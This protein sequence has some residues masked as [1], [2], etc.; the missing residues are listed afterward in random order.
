[1]TIKKLFFSLLY[2]A[3][4]ITAAAQDSITVKLEKEPDPLRSYYTPLPFMTP[5]MQ[6]Q[7]SLPTRLKENTLNYQCVYYPLPTNDTLGLIM[8]M[9]EEIIVYADCNLNK[10]FNDDV[11]YTFPKGSYTEGGDWTTLDM[12]NIPLKIPYKKDRTWPDPNCYLFM[13]IQFNNPTASTNTLRISNNVHQTGTFSIGGKEYK[14]ILSW[15]FSWWPNYYKISAIQEK[16][17]GEWKNASQYADSKNDLITIQGK[18]YHL[19]VNRKERTATLKLA[20]KETTK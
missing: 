18:K 4:A 2:V 17:E 12:D 19:T 8:V 9:G 20:K 5:Q 13:S 1:M 6:Q 3:T 7:Y 16:R 10:D 14:L 11:I 15:A